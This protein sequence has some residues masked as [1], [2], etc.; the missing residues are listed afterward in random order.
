M[1]G[2]ETRGEFGRWAESRDFVIDRKTVF[3]K[4]RHLQFDPDAITAL[5][6]AQVF[7]GAAGDRHDDIAA[8]QKRLHG[9]PR[10]SE[11]RFISLMA[12]HQVVGEEDDARGIGFGQ[13]D[14]AFVNERHEV[15]LGIFGLGA[16]IQIGRCILTQ[17]SQWTQRY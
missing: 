14:G 5:Q 12:K 13:T 9:Q 3:R 2:A 15:N 1:F 8:P 4:T 10:L 6:G 7:G 11:G 17:R 16:R